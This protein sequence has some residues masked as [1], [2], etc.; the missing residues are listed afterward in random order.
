MLHAV[1]RS[2]VSRFGMVVP[3]L[4]GAMLVA[5]L[6]H[7]GTP[8]E[9]V[10]TN[11]SAESIPTQ[12]PRE[13]VFIKGSLDAG[14]NS[15]G[16]IMGNYTVPS[17]RRLVIEHVSFG[18]NFVVCDFVSSVRLSISSAATGSASFYM[19]PLPP[20]A[21]PNS[22]TRF[23]RGSQDMKLYAAPGGSVQV[24]W[25]RTDVTCTATGSFAISGYLEEDLQ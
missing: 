24:S 18:T 7:A 21:L 12:H 4:A 5:G 3:V 16:G 19:N 20:M 1:I 6:A 13:P 14:V 8:K 23:T 11:L 15:G 25:T 10:V 17:D 22:S 2:V 9:V